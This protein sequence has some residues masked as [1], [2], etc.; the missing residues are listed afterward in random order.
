MSKNIDFQ[1]QLRKGTL[2]I[3]VLLIMEKEEV[4]P[5]QILEKATSLNLEL[6][7]GTLYPLLARL[8]I[9]SKVTSNWVES[10]KGPPRKY[11]KITPFGLEIIKQGIQAIK[12]LNNTLEQ[13]INN[14]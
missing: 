1:T 9:E 6:S 3:I 8:K 11:Y 2:E 12:Q 7:E 13:L 5:A 14:Q 10:S 4:Y